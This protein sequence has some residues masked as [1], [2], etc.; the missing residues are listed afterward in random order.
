MENK[1]NSKTIELQNNYTQQNEQALFKYKKDL[2]KLYLSKVF[3]KNS[4]DKQAKKVMQSFNEKIGIAM[5]KFHTE[6]FKAYDKEY[7]RK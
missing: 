2:D 5:V 6:I 3:E 4:F 1:I 7:K